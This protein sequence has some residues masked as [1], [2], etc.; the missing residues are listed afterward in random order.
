MKICLSALS[1]GRL[2]KWSSYRGGRLNKFD[3]TLPIYVRQENFV[4]AKFNKFFCKGLLNCY[5][6][7]FPNVLS[8]RFMKV[9]FSSV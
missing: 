6:V 2:V 5:I 1:I 4:G 7:R 3:F 9:Y 8:S